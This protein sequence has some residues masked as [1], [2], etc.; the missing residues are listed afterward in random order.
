RLAALE[1]AALRHDRERLAGGNTPVSDV[2]EEVQESV[3]RQ[4]EQAAREVLA[5]RLRALA[6]AEA[7][8]RQGRYG[9]CEVCG[10]P[11]PRARLRAVPEAV[12][13]VTCAEFVPWRRPRA[14]WRSL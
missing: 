14:T 9:L 12:W 7:R 6:H 13:C 3:A 11:I 5:A 2:M 8:V 10:E 1:R 4:N